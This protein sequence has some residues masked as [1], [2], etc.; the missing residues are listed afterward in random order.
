MNNVWGFGGDK[1][2]A[3]LNQFLIQP[4]VNYNLDG[5]WYIVSAPIITANWEAESSDRWT[6][7]VG[8]GVGKVFRIGK[9]PVN[10]NTQVYYN[11]DK[12]EWVGD[13]S[14]SWHAS[15]A[16][17]SVPSTADWPVRCW[18]FRAQTLMSRLPMRH[19]LTRSAAYAKWSVA[20]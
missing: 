19:W 4:F 12:P 9:Q 1:D 20:T 15:K 17:T 2:E 14:I 3:D 16:C 5:G 18:R 10:L 13:W 8:G 6:V 7:P 11:I